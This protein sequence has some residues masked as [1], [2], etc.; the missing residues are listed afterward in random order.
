LA[1][2]LRW[3]CPFPEE[4]E[5]ADID[6][7]VVGLDV[8]VAADG[9]VT[10]TRVLSD[11]GHGFARQARR[12]ALAKRWQPGLDR[13]GRPTAQSVLVNVRFVR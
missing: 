13:A 3:D 7:A 8:H 1:A 5:Q 11:P 2:G 4:A 12:C 9:S 10:S 6:D